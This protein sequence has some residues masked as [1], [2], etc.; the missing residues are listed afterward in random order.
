MSGL[1]S[2]VD[3]KAPGAAGKAAPPTAIGKED[4][5]EVVRLQIT[6]LQSEDLGMVAQAAASLYALANQAEAVPLIVPAIPRLI[7]LVNSQDINVQ[8]N[9][10][11]VI[12]SVLAAV[13]PNPQLYASTASSPG[14]A[15]SLVDALRSADGMLRLNAASA[16][17]ALAT[18]SQ[19]VELMMMA[20]ATPGLVRT[21]REDADE[22]VVEAVADAVCA[23]AAEPSRRDMLV[24]Q[25]GVEALTSLL[26]SS[27]GFGP[28]VS[29]RALLG[30]GMLIGSSPQALTRVAA[31]KE[32]V[33]SIYQMSRSTDP[34]VQAVATDVLQ[35]VLALSRLGRE[36]PLPH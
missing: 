24:T 27:R 9:A 10:C 29:V 30:L 21:L 3:G 28:D 23:I 25:E 36:M 20:G 34:D 4:V 15:E 18:R 33:R 16:L 7:Q 31:S 26:D 32:A 22:R 35:T 6:N 19:G 1:P 11:A 17:G 8:R 12:L 2:V 13:A 14:L 5:V